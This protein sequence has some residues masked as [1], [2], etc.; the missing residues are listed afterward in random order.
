M[1]KREYRRSDEQ[2]TVF[3]NSD[4]CTHCENCWRTLPAVFDPQ[5][6]PWVNPDAATTDEIAAAIND[7]HSG[8]IS[9]LPN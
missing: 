9:Q 3:W 8:A 1:A 4:L 7:C 6:R 5:R 2:L